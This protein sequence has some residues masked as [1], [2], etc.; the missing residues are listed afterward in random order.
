M[1]NKDHILR[2]PNDL[3][4]CHTQQLQPPAA[5]FLVWMT[6]V[7]DRVQGKAATLI[8]LAPT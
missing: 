4:C 5:S 3:C 6:K 7:K 2:Y 1:V 8:N